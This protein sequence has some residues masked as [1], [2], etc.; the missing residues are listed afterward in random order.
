MS[1]TYE[2]MH[3]LCLEMQPQLL[4]LELLD[5][6][7]RPPRSWILT[8]SD[9]AENHKHLLLSLQPEFLRFHFFKEKDRGKADSFSMNVLKKL[10]NSIVTQCRLLNEDR[11]LELQFRKN[12]E[13]YSLI[14][15]FF[16]KKP[17]LYLIDSQQRILD[18][19]FPI[20]SAVYVVPSRSVRSTP[21]SM[22][23]GKVL[24]ENHAVVEKHY[25]LLEQEK[26][27][28]EKKQDLEKAFN[29]LF[30]R[31]ESRKMQCLRD[32]EAC[33]EW[34]K[35]RHLATLLQAN[36]Y[37]LKKGMLEIKVSDWEAWDKDV[38]IS[39][40]R[41]AEPHEQ[42]AKQFRESKKLK[43]GLA[44]AER[45][46]REIEQEERNLLVLKEKLDPLKTIKEIHRFISIYP[47]L[48][49]LPQSKAV[50]EKKRPPEQ[51]PYREFQTEAG[52]LIWVGRNA[53]DNEVLTFSLARGSDYWLHARDYSGS[54]VVL[55]CKKNQEPD[56]E[57][58]HDAAQLAL[59]YS[60]AKDK[61][62]G[63]VSISQRKYVSRFGKGKK[64]KVTLS[65]HKILFARIDMDRIRQIQQRKNVF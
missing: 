64:G 18:V 16:S 52:L 56:Q 43:M 25:G 48:S 5:C 59:Y 14:A 42:V 41:E 57:S 47:F 10:K 1:L 28:Q 51:T 21:P 24:L 40:D 44:H 8:F 49:Q 35:K 6:A 46:L 2:Q 9:S 31:M 4:G 36:L 50:T 12:G 26:E 63:E 19:L 22:E 65:Q 39:L 45:R 34:E 61:G 30:K 15:E 32:L 37:R 17:N 54:H 13:S 55:R 29:K 3:L 58:I 38:V 23:K 11:I 20:T 60:K 27:F 7:Y 53:S 33:R 62:E